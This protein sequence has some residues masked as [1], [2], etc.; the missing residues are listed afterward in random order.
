MMRNRII[1]FALAFFMLMGVLPVN[2]VE[3]SDKGNTNYIREKIDY[4]NFSK[5]FSQT[6]TRFSQSD[7]KI[8][9]QEDV[10][11]N[12][13]IQIKFNKKLDKD[14]LNAGKIKLKSNDG[15][16][17]VLDKKDIWINHDNQIKSSDRNTFGGKILNI[18]LNS[19]NRSGKYDLR[20]DTLYKLVLEKGFVDQSMDEDIEIS[21]LT[22]QKK[23]KG[24][25]TQE[26]T[27]NGYSSDNRNQDD[28]TRLNTTKLGQL[29]TSIGRDK[30]SIYVHLGEGARWNADKLNKPVNYGNGKG[31][32]DKEDLKHFKFYEV[33]KSYKEDANKREKEF[34]YNEKREVHFKDTNKMKELELSS[35]E[36]ISVNGR[37][38]VIKITP[39]DALEFYNMYYLKLDDK[40][41]LTDIYGRKLKDSI[42]R[43]LWTVNDEKKADD[44]P[45]WIMDRD[46]NDPYDGNED[47]ITAEE[48]IENE[49]SPDK[50]LIYRLYGVPKYNEYIDKDEKKPIIINVDGEVIPNP[51]G[52]FNKMYPNLYKSSIYMENTLK[53]IRLKEEHNASKEVAVKW[54]ELKYFTGEDGKRKTKIYLYPKGE[55]DSGKSYELLMPR[56]TFVN[57][58]AKT[59]DRDLM[60]RFNI[61]GEKVKDRG[62]NTIAYTGDLFIGDTSRAGLTLDIRGFNFTEDIRSIRF[63]NV[64]TGKEIK[65]YDSITSKFDFINVDRII[66]S[67]SGS[68]LRELLKEGNGGKYKVY[69]DFG[70]GKA[71]ESVEDKNSSLVIYERPYVLETEPGKDD[72]DVDKKDVYIGSLGDK[73]GNYLTVVFDNINGKLKKNEDIAISKF[74]FYENLK[75]SDILI[76]TSREIGYEG[77]ENVKDI[78]EYEIKT[79]GVK[80]E[81][82][83]NDYSTAKLYIDDD[84][85]RNE[86]DINITLFDHELNVNPNLKEET[87][88]LVT[89]GGEEKEVTLTE[90]SNNSGKFEGK[91]K[92]W[93]S[94]STQDDKDDIRVKYIKR[95]SGDGEI[96]KEIVQDAK[97]VDKIDHKRRAQLYIEKELY[98]KDEDVKITLIDKEANKKPD[99]KETLDVNISFAD[100]SNESP[101]NLTLVE[102]GN[103]TGIFTGIFKKE[104]SSDDILGKF[105][106]T[107]TYKEDKSEGES[108]KAKIYIPITNDINDDTVYKA[109][110]PAGIVYYGDKDSLDFDKWKNKAYEWSFKTSKGSIDPTVD[111][112]FK[113]SAPEDYDDKFNMTLNGENFDK[114]TTKVYFQ[115]MSGEK[116]EVRVSSSESNEKMLRIYLP[117]GINRLKTGLYDI[118]VENEGHG[119]QI[120]Q[121]GVFSIVPKGDYVP[122]E[123]FEQT[124]NDSNGE[125]IE[126]GSLKKYIKTSNDTLELKKE[127]INSSKV[128]LNLDEIMGENV[129]SRNIG[130]E[131]SKGSTINQL[132]IESKWADINLSGIRLDSNSSNN[133]I[134]IRTGRTS[135]TV[136]DNIKKRLKGNSIK[137]EFIEVGGN[138]YKADKLNLSIPFT[139]SNGRNLK[140][141]KYDEDTRRITEIR[142][143]SQNISTGDKKINV[144][145][146]NALPSD[147]VTKGIFVIV[148]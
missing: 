127:Y 15:D 147:N 64:I 16:Y 21:F 71:A 87:T 56:D 124:D 40:D 128:N 25:A 98:L 65:F 120:I 9:N 42:D 39:K 62:I 60:L 10:I 145:L 81:E 84:K 114:N 22:G 4:I 112:S 78:T 66:F 103:N 53:N 43:Y 69:I 47:Q 97:I 117:T 113:G 100:E 90:T 134:L 68:K 110:L 24:I 106:I 130:Y 118:L 132:I 31:L 86:D 77:F 89:I 115:D 122:N 91:V 146:T 139:Q 32:L 136:R 30:K 121:Y 105:T 119:S 55:L 116:Y 19:A 148:E 63:K 57:R 108:G 2:L 102:T 50:S 93:L 51:N 67:L 61:E 95:Q 1:S 33:P 141:L 72:W 126:E 142:L 28:I 76:D 74:E 23:K 75:Q 11:V 49:N 6:Y 140:L 52:Y 143:T 46:P 99:T 48:I 79:S 135:P 129:W 125:V 38:N 29:D 80:Q 20:K 37:N 27:V 123:D 73:S 85:Y 104:A 36:I 14:K 54:Y 7:K 92:A 138:N 83:N 82:I 13:V 107:Y 8:N 109:K 18:D 59:F 17:F 111:T 45:R 44:T 5:D 35:A 144:E 133:N 41:I 12:P 26:F 131:G 101:K 70:S 58:S 137:S 3:A 96:Y 88:V 34:R 94:D